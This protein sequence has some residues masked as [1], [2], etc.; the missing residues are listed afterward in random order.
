MSERDIQTWLWDEQ[1]ALLLRYRRKEIPWWE[2]DRRWE[3]NRVR[4]DHYRIW[5]RRFSV[6]Q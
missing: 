1:Y 5:V 3:A 2:L 4:A 6:E